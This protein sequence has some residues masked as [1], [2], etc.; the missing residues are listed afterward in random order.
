MTQQTHSVSAQ[1]YWEPRPLNR[2]G[3]LSSWLKRMRDACP[4]PQLHQEVYLD[5]SYYRRVDCQLMRQRIGY[6]CIG[7]RSDGEAIWMRGCVSL[8]PLHLEL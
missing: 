4:Q 8:L 5:T 3:D 7:F 6:K 2:K 1:A